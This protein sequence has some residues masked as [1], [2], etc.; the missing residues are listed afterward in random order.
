MQQIRSLLLAETA[1]RI[2]NLPGVLPHVAPGFVALDLSP[3]FRSRWNVALGD[4][5]GM[6]LFG[7]MRPG[8]Y[9]G[10][11]LFVPGRGGNLARGRGFLRTMFTDYAASTIV[12]HTPVDN[13]PARA[14][15]RALGFTP[16]GASV[17]PSGRSC[18]TYILERNQ[19]ANL[20]AV[21]SAASAPSQ[22]P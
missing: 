20:S 10:H 1:N 11:F 15:T 2:A 21:S 16:Q 18:V 17:S 4:G 14:L 19:W 12:G 5:D 22:G 3:F 6:A 7:W 9:E 8:V 13:L